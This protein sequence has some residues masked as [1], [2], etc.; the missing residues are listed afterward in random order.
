MKEKKFEIFAK[1]CFDC[2]RYNLLCG[3]YSTITE[4]SRREVMIY[5]TAVRFNARNLCYP[6]TQAMTLDTLNSRPVDLNFFS[7]I[8]EGEEQLQNVTDEL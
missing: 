4:L 6:K 8:K 1:K 5:V 3:E 2:K 7:E